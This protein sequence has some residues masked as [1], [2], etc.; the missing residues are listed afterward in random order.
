MHTNK[1]LIDSEFNDIVHA[2][3]NYLRY[4]QNLIMDMQSKYLK[5]TTT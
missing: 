5:A 1:E 4:Q 3:M 2:V